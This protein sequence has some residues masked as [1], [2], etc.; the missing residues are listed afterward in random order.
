MVQTT[1]L[2]SKEISMQSATER[3]LEVA[4]PLFADRPFDAVSTREIAK[5]ANVNL[6]AISYHFENKEGLYRAVFEKI[7]ADLEPIRVGFAMFL[8]T[9]MAAAGDDRAAL[10]AIVAEFVSRLMDSIMSPENPR[11]RMRLIIR[12]IQHPSDCFDTVMQ[13]HINIMHDL[14]G[15]LVAKATGEPE[16]SE[17]VRLMTHSVLIVCLQYALSEPLVKAR[18]GWDQVGPAEI[19]K[20]KSVLTVTVLRILNLGEFAERLIL[21]NSE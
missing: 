20:I 4:G 5:A 11:W 1:D 16:A 9:K 12:E 15:I 21:E 14:I 2:K 18:L 19:G 3:M 10:A 13:G 6:S 17:K 7:I 8:R